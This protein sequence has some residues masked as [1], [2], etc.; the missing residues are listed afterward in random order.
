MINLLKRIRQKMLSEN[1]LSI[2]LAYAIGEIF[3]VVFGILIAFQIVIFL[4]VILMAIIMA[5]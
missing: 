3:L 1:K 2:Y 4:L 5:A